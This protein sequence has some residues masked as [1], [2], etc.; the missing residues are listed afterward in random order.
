MKFIDYTQE[1]FYKAVK[2][3]A[4]HLESCFPKNYF[5]AVVS[6][7]N[8][9]LP[10]GEAISSYLKLEHASILAKSYV[11]QSRGSLQLAI[12]TE[13]YNY[14]RI[15]I[16]DDIADSGNTLDQIIKKFP[17]KEVY[18][19]TLFYKQK[20]IVKPDFYCH[21]ITDDNWINFP[22]EKNTTKE[23]MNVQSL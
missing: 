2:V 14:G 18:T 9:G 19:I 6:V 4:N 17:L 5:D 21:T 15:I 3:I 7:A 11:G 12:P 22:W 20:S 8:G 23:S 13:V 16:V 1:E 10:I